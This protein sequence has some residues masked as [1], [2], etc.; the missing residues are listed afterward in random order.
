M[1][2]KIIDF[3]VRLFVTD[4]VF[5]SVFFDE[6]GNIIYIEPYKPYGDANKIIIPPIVMKLKRFD[7]EIINSLIFL[8]LFTWNKT[9]HRAQFGVEHERL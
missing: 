4:N 3:L 7:H 6:N 9:I 5:F 1:I 8:G 2:K